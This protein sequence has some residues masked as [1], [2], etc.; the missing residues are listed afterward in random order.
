LYHSVQMS[1]DSYIAGPNGEMGWMVQD[2]DRDDR[3]LNYV[4]EL[5]KSVDK[6]SLIDIFGYCMSIPAKLTSLTN[7]D[8]ITIDD[9][10]SRN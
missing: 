5:T 1:V 3:F 2:R 7:P 6:S 4:F 10:A 9:A 8:K